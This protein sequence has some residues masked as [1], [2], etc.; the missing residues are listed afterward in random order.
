[1]KIKIKKRT[2]LVMLLAVILIMTA[3][4]AVSASAV[5]KE[6][7]ET[8]V[9]A[10]SNEAVAG[11]IFVWFLCAIAFL[12]I[13]QKIDSF[14]SSLGINVGNTGGNMLAEA[15]IACRGVS[16]GKEAIGGG[17]R[18]GGG[19]SGRIGAAAGG[20]FL[21]GGLAGAVSRNFSNSAISGA[22]N[23]GGNFV[24]RNAFQNS[25]SKGGDFA[26]NVI[27]S[28]ANGDIRQMGSITGETANKSLTSYM[29]ETGKTDAPAY[30]NVEIG[31]GRIMGTETSATNP[32]GQ[33]FGMYSTNQYMAPEQGSYET[34]SSVDGSKWY[35]QY[36][37]S[38]GDSGN[39][40][41]NESATQKLPPVPK[42]KDRL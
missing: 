6:E 17:F 3:L 12:K 18:S 15:I 22:T 23:Q 11:N 34:V 35:K 28:V 16:M 31:G 25:M 4:L 36:A 20:G 21:A 7:V 42:R 32:E 24:T 40:G 27:G 19:G 8:K 33:Q 1:M 10:T 29:G 5:T 2:K 37:T 41:Y 30:S 14:M 9:A 13:S 39:N 38:A 26:N